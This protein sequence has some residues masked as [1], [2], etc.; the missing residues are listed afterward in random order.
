VQIQKSE[1]SS[2]AASKDM[3]D[4]HAKVAINWSMDPTNVVR[5]YKEIGDEDDVE[6][7][8]LTP[9]VNEVM[10]AATS[11]RTA[12]EVLK[13]RV[14]LKQDIDDGLKARMA[15]YGIKIYDVS[16]VDLQFSKDFAEAIERK[17]VAEQDAQQAVYVAKK[18][19]QE[20]NAEIER[21]KGQ[22]EAQRL[23]KS[24]ITAEILQQRAI[25]KWDGHFPTYMGGG[26][27][28][29]INVKP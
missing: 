20:A 25:E 26:A 1:I 6:Q 22:A 19:T 24:T 10:K 16:I 28:P 27:L 15:Q 2:A 23:M 3:Q 29:F 5:T 4:V 7:R 21:A 11:K 14:E 17:Q 13:L 9:A 18:A 12:E 8:I